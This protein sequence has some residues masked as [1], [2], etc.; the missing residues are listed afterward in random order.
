M[1]TQPTTKRI[2]IANPSLDANNK[3]FLTSDVSVGATTLEVA[4]TSGKQFLTTGTFDYYLL[5][6]G[7]EKEKGEFVL[8]DASDAATDDNSFKVSATKYSHEASDAI[9]Y[10][11]YNQIKIYGSLTLTGTKTLIDT[12]DIDPTEQYTDYIYEDSTYSYF[13]TAYYNST[14]DVISAYSDAIESTSFGL[15]SAKKVIESGL[16]KAMTSID[17]N[18]TSKLNWDVAIETINDGLDEIILRKKRWSF[19]HKIDITSI[20]TVA[21][22]V[23][24]EKPTDLSHLEHIIINNQ[25]LKWI[26]H[27]QY[28]S[29]TQNGVVTSSGEP[30][31][32]TTKNNKYYLYPTPNSVQDVTIE[33]YKYPT[34]ITSLVDNLDRAF[35]SI[36]SYYCAA[37]FAWIRGNDK[38]GDKLYTLFQKT[39][40]QQCEEYSGPDQIGDSEVVENVAYLDAEVYI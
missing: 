22:Q 6:E 10:S 25:T 8:V 15:T 39:L 31:W 17:E 9:I 16:R 21:E 4:S 1:S 5:I 29:Y 37:N 7:Y 23:Y 18:P 27:L 32:Y 20:D 33:Y 24:I 2:R 38:R 14:L 26:S 35:V 34:E 30:Q 36:L 19:L 3:T 11:P 12:I 13:F 40:E 28:D